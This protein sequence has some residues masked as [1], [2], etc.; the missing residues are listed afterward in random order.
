[1]YND[2]KNL[3]YNQTDHKIRKI[4]K[5]VDR[6]YGDFEYKK[7]LIADL[8]K[9]LK[10]E[11]N[12]PSEANLPDLTITNISAIDKGHYF[13]FTITIKNIG[14][15]ATT[16]ETNLITTIEGEEVELTVPAL[17]VDETVDRYTSFPYDPDAVDTYSLNVNSEVNEER[18][19]EE[20]DYSN[21]IKNQS[22]EIKDNYTQTG[23]IV[24]VHNPEGVEIGTIQIG[25]GQGGDLALIYIDNV[26]SAGSASDPFGTDHN[27]VIP[28][29]SGNRQIKIDL[30]GQIYTQNVNVIEN[31]ISIVTFV[32]SRN[33]TQITFEGDDGFGTKLYRHLYL[34]AP[35]VPYI[36]QIYGASISYITMDGDYI[37]EGV[38]AISNDILASTSP[39][40]FWNFG[41]RG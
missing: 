4:R 19:I 34:Y 22:F 31:E 41:V 28:C 3:N 16:E 32:V 8:N 39:Y 10:I 1:M 23:V 24:H 9:Q 36:F 13:E 15:I 26:F 11:I 35:G 14:V 27:I 20:R 29:L 25:D 40:D 5:M 17:D 2:F 33:S 18:N 37:I 21:N 12:L 6:L 7:H 38:T 30:N